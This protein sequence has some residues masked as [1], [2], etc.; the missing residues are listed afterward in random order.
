MPVI[1]G[2]T[3]VAANTTTANLLVGNISEFL[4][5]PSI[6]NLF[7]AADLPGLLTTLLIGNDVTIDDQEMSD[8]NRFPQSPEDFLERGGGFQGDRLTLRLHNPTAGII[9]AQ[10]RL[11][12]ES[13]Q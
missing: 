2:T 4:G 11:S 13:V 7:A 9:I 3:T 8:A 1:T 6:V 12:I 5:R 10:W